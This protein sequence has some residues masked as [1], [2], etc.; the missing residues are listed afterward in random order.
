[1]WTLFH[2]IIEYKAA[3]CLFYPEFLMNLHQLKPVMA[4]KEGGNG[5]Y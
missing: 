3:R 1:M 2:S 4:G 5:C